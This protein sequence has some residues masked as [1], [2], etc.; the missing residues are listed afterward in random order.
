[1]SRFY[2]VGRIQYG[3]LRLF[4]LPVKSGASEGGLV[5]ANSAGGEL[6]AGV[7]GGLFRSDGLASHVPVSRLG[8]VLLALLGHS[9]S[10]GEGGQGDLVL[11]SLLAGGGAEAQGAS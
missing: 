11:L 5:E 7:S 6:V 3:G 9:A 1:L 4:I 10:G 8:I 2:L